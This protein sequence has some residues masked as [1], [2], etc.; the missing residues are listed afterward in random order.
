MPERKAVRAKTIMMIL[1]ESMPLRRLALGLMP[2]DSTIVPNAVFRTNRVTAATTT[3]VLIMG[4]GR[5]RKLPCPI[6]RK[7]E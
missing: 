1:W 3:I 7:G 2:T 4:I 6:M 5:K